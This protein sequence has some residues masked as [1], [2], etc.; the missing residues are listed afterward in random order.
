LELV[1]AIAPLVNAETRDEVETAVQ[2]VDRLILA[3]AEVIRRRMTERPAAW[4][5]RGAPTAYTDGVNRANEVVTYTQAWLNGN[6]ND[7]RRAAAQAVVNQ[8]ARAEA[9]VLQAETHNEI[10]AAVNKLNDH[11]AHF[12]Q[13]TQAPSG[14]APGYVQPPN[15][16]NLP[17]DAPP[18][19][20]G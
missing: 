17:D 11:Y 3:L 14:P 18:P 9:M 5:T 19:T 20:Y 16:D 7:F 13:L 10:T 1:N 2:D 4:R 6:P 12:Q 8:I 15:Y